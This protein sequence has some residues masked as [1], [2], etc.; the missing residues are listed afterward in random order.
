MPMIRK[1]EALQPLS[2]FVVMVSVSNPTARSFYPFLV[3]SALQRQRA[4]DST[5][6]ITRRLDIMDRGTSRATIEVMSS[7]TKD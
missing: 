2:L 4:K 3:D 7:T 1:I 5:T 6:A